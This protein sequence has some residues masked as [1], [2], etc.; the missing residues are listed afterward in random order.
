VTLF[1]DPEDDIFDGVLGEN[2]E[3]WPRALISFDFHEDKSLNISKEIPAKDKEK[4][5]DTLTLSPLKEATQETLMDFSGDL[6]SQ[7]SHYPPVFNDN[8]NN[9]SFKLHIVP[10]TMDVKSE[11]GGTPDADIF[12]DFPSS[13][14]PL[15][16]EKEILYQSGGGTQEVVSQSN[17]IK[18]STFK[19]K[20]ATE[21][22]KRKETF[23]DSFEF[24]NEEKQEHENNIQKK[25]AEMKMTI[26]NLEREKNMLKKNEQTY[27][28]KL[29]HS[30]IEVEKLKFNKE[31]YENTIQELQNQLAQEKALRI[32]LEKEKGQKKQAEAMTERKDYQKQINERDSPN[33]LKCYEPLFSHKERKYKE[34]IE[35]LHKQIMQLKNEC[36]LAKTQVE[37][38]ESIIQNLQKEIYALRE[39]ESH[40]QNTPDDKDQEHYDKLIDICSTHLFNNRQQV[41]VGI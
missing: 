41:S 5:E 7:R 19:E 32:L 26:E 2:D 30:R 3:E 28:L 35:S 36:K 20:P 37:C 12:P 14:N 39:K 4:V 33:Q 22:Q 25:M 18:P 23:G 8:N 17:P 34:E 10:T 38:D 24:T 40:S 31:N 6:A 27:H 16:M 21:G 13:E 9:T 29:N 11:K 15:P 1:D